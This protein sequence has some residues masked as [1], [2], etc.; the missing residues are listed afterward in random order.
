HSG[1]LQIGA[2]CQENQAHGQDAADQDAHEQTVQ[3]RILVRKRGRY[4]RQPGS[5]GENKAFSSTAGTGDDLRRHLPLAAQKPTARTGYFVGYNG[6]LCWAL[7]EWSQQDEILSN[8]S[9]QCSLLHHSVATRAT[10]LPTFAE[11]KGLLL[12]HI[13]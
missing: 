11:K 12:L 2:N 6:I 10:A 7:H 8:S 13:A 3:V 5:V 1:M 4:R 9:Q